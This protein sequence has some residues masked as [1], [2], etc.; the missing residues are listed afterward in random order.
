VEIH[1]GINEDSKDEVDEAIVIIL[2]SEITI[3]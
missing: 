2:G 1:L 3:L